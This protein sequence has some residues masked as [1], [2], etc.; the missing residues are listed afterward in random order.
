MAARIGLIG[1]YNAEVPAHRGIPL[2]LGMAAAQVGCGVEFAW[3]HTS[4]LTRPVDQLTRFTGIWSVP[5]SPYANTEGA[6]EAIRFARES[7]VPFLGTCGGFQHALLEFARNVLGLREA[8]HAEMNPGAEMA[9][10][11]PLACDLV[12]K[13]GALRFEVGSRLHRIYGIDRATEEY[14]CRYA[15]NPK[16]APL[17]AGSDLCFSAHDDVG[18]PRAFEHL[19]HPFFFGTLFQPERSALKENARPHPLILAFVRAASETPP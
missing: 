5:A 14:R 16:Y 9:L 10:L 19:T 3:V 12:E 1:D 11:S 4:E 2:A 18:D 15:L 6:L 17:F 8:E 7:W 13:S